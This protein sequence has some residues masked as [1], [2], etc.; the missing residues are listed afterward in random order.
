MLYA[1][2]FPFLYKGLENRISTGLHFQT[3]H[4]PLTFAF[5]FYTIHQ[6]ESSAKG[7]SSC[8][9]CY[10]IYT[11]FLHGEGCILK[12][13]LYLTCLDSQ[14]LSI[15]CVSICS[16]STVVLRHRLG[17]LLY[18]WQAALASWVLQQTMYHKKFSS[19]PVFE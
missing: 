1:Q 16:A 10:L 17:T 18:S 6:G 2:L 14:C 11:E 13:G 15:Q 12:D 19:L 5:R 8:C 7:K 4:I 3:M 9:S